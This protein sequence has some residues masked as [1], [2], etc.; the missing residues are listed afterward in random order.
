MS[1]TTLATFRST[2]VG[3]ADFLDAPFNDLRP[4][5][6]TADETIDLTAMGISYAQAH[7]PAPEPVPAV[8]RAQVGALGRPRE[9]A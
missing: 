7:E 5:E 3:S 8:S 1:A 6:G 2:I 9:F 4:F